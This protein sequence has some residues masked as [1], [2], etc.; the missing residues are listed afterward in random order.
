[1]PQFVWYTI[2]ILQRDALSILVV[3]QS[4]KIVQCLIIVSK[5]YGKQLKE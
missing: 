4:V 3:L 5:M 2:L 1:M